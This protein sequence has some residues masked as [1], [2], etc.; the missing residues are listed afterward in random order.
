MMVTSFICEL[1]ICGFVIVK[2]KLGWL[3]FSLPPNLAS[4]QD[5]KARVQSRKAETWQNGQ[6][7]I[8]LHWYKTD[9]MVVKAVCRL[10]GQPLY[11]FEGK[12]TAQP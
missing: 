6:S 1:C 8:R 2:D 9:E 3:D 11:F 10:V 4:R 12:L 5:I 7:K